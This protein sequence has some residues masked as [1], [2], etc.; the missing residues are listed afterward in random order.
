MSFDIEIAARTVLMEASGEPDEGQRAVAWA[1]CNRHRTDKWYAGQ[2]LAETCLLPFQFSSW[3]TEDRNRRRIA[4][5]ADDDPTLIK[6]R[7]MIAEAMA[8]S[9]ADPSNGASHYYAKTLPLAPDW[10]K[11]KTPCAEIGA[12]LFFK[13]IL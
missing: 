5:M 12:H 8:N 1:I 11:G 2:T 13:D 7:G 6:A 10:A 3:N 4:R 9:S